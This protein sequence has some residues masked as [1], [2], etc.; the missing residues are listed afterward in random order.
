MIKYRQKA[1]SELNWVTIP[2]GSSTSCDIS[3]SPTA[4]VDTGYYT[5]NLEQIDENSEGVN[6]VLYSEQVTVKVCETICGCV[7]NI[8]ADTSFTVYV[9]YNPTIKYPERIIADES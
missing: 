1:G 2:S 4:D 3:L 7:E 6:S 8:I 5:L 9:D